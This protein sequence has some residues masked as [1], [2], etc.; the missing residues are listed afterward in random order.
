MISRKNKLIKGKKYRSCLRF[1]LKIQESQNQ[2]CMDWF[3]KSAWR[4]FSKL[5]C[6][7]KLNYFYEEKYQYLTKTEN[8]Y[9]ERLMIDLNLSNSKQLLTYKNRQRTFLK[10]IKEKG[11]EYFKVTKVWL[12][13]EDNYS[14]ETHLLQLHTSSVTKEKYEIIK[15]QLK[16]EK[17]PN[18]VFQAFC[19]LEDNNC[20]YKIGSYKIVPK[21]EW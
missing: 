15:K 11:I 20:T 9:P 6:T 8:E 19:I 13:T 7:F 21:N 18:I 14:L 16:E 3:F 5:V 4:I 10:T 1:R 12:I 17:Y 2:K